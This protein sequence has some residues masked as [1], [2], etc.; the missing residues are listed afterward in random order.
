MGAGNQT[1]IYSADG[2]STGTA[3]TFQRRRRDD[4]QIQV[5]WTPDTGTTVTVKIQGS[6]DGGQNSPWTT[7]KSFT[8]AE[9][10]G[11]AGSVVETILLMLSMRVVV[12]NTGD[13]DDL[14]EVW[15]LE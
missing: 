14:V 3:H 2:N 12:S 5:E 11:A 10:G 13:T 8:E 1:L 15:I 7:I 9:F 4:G 6:A